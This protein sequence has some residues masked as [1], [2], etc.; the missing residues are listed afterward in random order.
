MCGA[1]E[2]TLPKVSTSKKPDEYL[3][4]R[5]LL[6]LSNTPKMKDSIYYKCRMYKI[7]AQSD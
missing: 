3:F 7:I 6:F 4:V 2:S 1:A 5:L